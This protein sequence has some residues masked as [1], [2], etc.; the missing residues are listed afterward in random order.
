MDRVLEIIER[1]NQRGGRMLSVVDL[2]ERRTLTLPQAAWLVSRVEAGSSW[3]VGALPGGAGKTAVMAAL[4]GF[5]PA[6]E[7][8]WLAAPEEKWQAAAPGDCVVAYE[9]S[10]GA[11]DAYVWGEAV[12]RFAALGTRG[13]RL[14]TNLHADTLAAARVQVV[15]DN[16]VPAA[17]FDGFGMFLPITVDR[18]AS[19][20]ERRIERLHY[21]DGKGWR[22]LEMA[23]PVAPREQA[24]AEFLADQ[25]GEKCRELGPLRNKWLRWRD[26]TREKVC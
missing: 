5:L 16:G 22:E 1:A 3:L 8:V 6:G 20:T 26:C 14:V 24:I 4:L 19:G 23:P 7:R 15:R 18:G 13:C 21:R 12:R 11:Y 25:L 10:P 2:L 17:E 9:I